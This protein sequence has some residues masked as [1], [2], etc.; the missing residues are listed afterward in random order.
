MD[1]PGRLVPNTTSVFTSRAGNTPAAQ[2]LA[3]TALAR[4]QVNLPATARA[5]SVRGGVTDVQTR[6]NRPALPEAQTSAVPPLDRETDSRIRQLA[7]QNRPQAVAE[8]AQPPTAVEIS[9]ANTTPEIR[10][11]LQA[12]AQEVGQGLQL[13]ARVEARRTAAQAERSAEQAAENSQEREVRSSQS[14][15]RE[16]QTEA[17]HLERELGQTERE[18]RQR[19]TEIN[20]QGSAPRTSSGPRIDLLAA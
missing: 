8:S 19:Q 14:E 3:R 13:E 4:V 10:E 1:R 7:A 17:R 18:I 11:N 2:N 6:G 15:V 20:R 16:L 12:N 5:T 9:R